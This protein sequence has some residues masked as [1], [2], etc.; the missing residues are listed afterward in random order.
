MMSM[1]RTDSGGHN[2][3]RQNRKL[4]VCCD[5]T[6]NEPYHF[7]AHTNVVKMVRA[8]LPADADGVAQMVYYHPGVGTGNIVDRFM[9]G[10]L[11]IGLSANVQAA[12]DFLATNFVDGD[13]I[14]LFGFSRGAYTARSLAGLIGQVGGLLEKRDMDLF[15]FVY[16]I[17]RSRE[18]RKA[19]AS[20]TKVDTERTIRALFSAKQLAGNFDRLTQAILG[21]RTTQIFFIG[22]WDTVGALGIPLGWLRWVGKRLYDFHDTDLSE[23]IRF[24][25]HALAIDERRKSFMPTLWTRPKGRGTEQD[26]N[27]QTL[28]QVWFAGAHSNVGGGYPDGALSDIAF[29]W[30]AE[31]AAS[32]QWTNDTG[33]PLAFDTEYLKNIDPGM[34]LLRDS[35]EGLVWKLAG[36][37]RRTVSGQPPEGKETCE[38]IHWSAR[39]RMQCKAEGR[40]SP[41]PYQPDNL[42]K[43][44][45][46]PGTIVTELSELE[47]KY[48]RWD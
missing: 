2:V 47:R 44:L 1:A 23:R 35:S 28:E 9:G 40:F 12:Y 11:G 24:A 13:K 27:K 30:M 3:A 8:I 19:L 10:T 39:F 16:E 48:H 38:A 31:K 26:A 43:A 14:Y 46:Q 22:V 15:P 45:E 41:F 5:G 20:G 6:W 17:Y 18:H 4:I 37:K 42:A 29:L 32:A 7:G 34:G 21:N 33:R 25:Y 36:V